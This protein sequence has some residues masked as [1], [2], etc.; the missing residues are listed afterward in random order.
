MFAVFRTTLPLPHRVS[1]RREGH[2][3]NDPSVGHKAG[4]DNGVA[5]NP[6]VLA[7]ADG[8][9]AVSGNLLERQQEDLRLRCRAALEPARVGEPP[10][11]RN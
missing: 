9:D 1:R 10:F 4:L 11:A 8:G 3:M 5:R 2:E 7:I 6:S